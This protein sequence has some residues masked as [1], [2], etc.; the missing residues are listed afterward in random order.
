M[1]KRLDTKP[2]KKP[3]PNAES[4]T[5]EKLDGRWLRRFRRDLL[6]WYRKSYRPLP[7]RTP[8]PP[9]QRR[10]QGKTSHLSK[11]NRFR[12]ANHEPNPYHVL[13]SEL[14]LQQTQVATVIPYFLAFVKAFPTIQDLAT[15]NTQRVMRHWQGL[16]YYRRAKHLHEA[17]CQIVRDHAG[18]VPQRLDDLLKLPGVGRYTAGAIASIAYHQR[19]PVLDGNVSRILARLFAIQHPID[20]PK[21]KSELWRLAEALVPARHPGEFNQALMDLGATICVPRRPRCS[22]C[23]VSWAC[24]SWKHD[25]ADRWPVTARRATPI[26]MD[27]HIIALRRRGRYLLR[28]RGNDGMWPGMWEFPTI[29]SSVD[30]SNLSGLQAWI[31]QQLGLMVDGLDQVGQFRHLTTHRTIMFSL[32]QAQG[33]EGRLRRGVGQWQRLNHVEEFP[34]AKPQCRAISMILKSAP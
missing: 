15:A 23:P 1:S 21:V 29:E 9:S 19:Q 13:V 6:S 25:Q 20:L 12:A 14:M 18:R 24:R 27:H 30:T 26:R 16:G 28:Q 22:Q 33:V 2:G 31:H 17:A 8:P 3:S 32:W 5:S 10:P 34:L 4:I 11:K 7:W